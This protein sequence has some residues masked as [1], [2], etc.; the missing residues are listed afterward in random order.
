M[1]YKEGTGYNFA[2]RDGKFVV[3]TPEGHL[4]GTNSGIVLQVTGNQFLITSD[5]YSVS[6]TLDEINMISDQ[7]CVDTDC[8]IAF[9]RIIKLFPK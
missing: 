9:D 6:F 5:T 4:M 1:G 3:E 7:G 8:G 2:N